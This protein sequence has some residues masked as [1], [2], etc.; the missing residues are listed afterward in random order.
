MTDHRSLSFWMST[1]DDDLTPRPAL[2]GDLDVDVAIVGG[3]YTGLW[4]AYYLAVA[5]PSRTVAVL[6]S[7][8]CGFGASGRNGGWCS[9]L[10]PKSAAALS[11]MYGKDRALA[12]YRAMRSTVDEV[13][14]AAAEEG[15]DCHYRKGGTVVLARTAAQLARAREEVAHAREYGFEPE[16]LDLLDAGEASARCGAT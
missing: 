7:D 10:F 11:R 12:L 9:A 4:T 16:D 1:V 8:I 3:G 13:G 5:D 15:I 6:E 14:R 2:D